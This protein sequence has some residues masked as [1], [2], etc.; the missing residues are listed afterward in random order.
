MLFGSKL[1]ENVH[2][3]NSTSNFETLKKKDKIIQFTTPTTT[4][5]KIITTTDNL[6][7]T[8]KQSSIEQVL[9]QKNILLQET[10]QDNGLNQSI[11]VNNANIQTTN[12]IAKDTINLNVVKEN[13][14]KQN[15]NSQKIVSSTRIATKFVLYFIFKNI[16]Y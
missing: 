10:S 7:T 5:F 6:S 1:E 9:I 14:L 11:D 8:N 12:N 4:T 3:I 16:V 15:T 2:P 13:A